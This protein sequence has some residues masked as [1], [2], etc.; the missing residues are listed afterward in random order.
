MIFHITTLTELN[1]SKISGYYSPLGFEKEG[2]IH[3][4]TQ[5]QVV[6]VANRFYKGKSG[7]VLLRIN[8]ALI[9]SKIVFENLEGG[10]INYPHIYGLIPLCA[11]EGYSP[12]AQEQSTFTFPTNWVDLDN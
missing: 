4:S 7:L 1:S 5:D 3:C 2:F 12:I 8:T 11:I 10:T 6:T 9:K